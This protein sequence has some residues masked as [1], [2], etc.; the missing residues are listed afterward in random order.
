MQ[1]VNIWLSVLDTLAVI[2]LV[3]FLNKKH[4]LTGRK[5]GKEL[6]WKVE[7]EIKMYK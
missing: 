3:N 6:G 4:S 2:R 7:K 1:I 5:L